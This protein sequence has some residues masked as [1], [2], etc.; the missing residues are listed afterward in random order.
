MQFVLIFLSFFFVISQVHAGNNWPV[1]VKLTSPKLVEVEPGKIVTCNFL[2]YNNQRQEENFT[3]KLKIPPGW[4][5]ILPVES[6]FKLAEKERQARLF[7]FSAPVFCHAGQYRITYVVRSQRD[8]GIADSRTFTVKVLPVSKLEIFIEK[9]PEIVIAG[10]DYQVRL[11][12]INRGNSKTTIKLQMKSSCGYP[13]KLDPSEITLGV[14]ESQ[15]LRIAVKTDR[16]LKKRFRHILKIKAEAE[17]LQNGDAVT[18]GTISVEIIPR[19][20]I[21][22]D[23][24][25]RFPA[26]I[27]LID[28]GKDGK[29]GFQA[30]FAGSGYLSEES[31]RKVSF[32]F[33]AKDVQDKSIY[34][35][36]SVYWFNYY[37]KLLSLHFG[38]R[39]Y[40][41]SPLTGANYGRGAEFNIHPKKFGFGSFYSESRWSEQRERMTG[42]HLKY[43][44]NDM[45]NIKGNFLSKC[46]SGYSDNIYSMQAEIGSTDNIALGLEYGFSGSSR[47]NKLSDKAYRIDLDGTLFKYIDY[48]FEKIYA[49]PKYLGNYN[50]SDHTAGTMAFSIFHRLRGKFF[51]YSHKDNLDLNN[52]IANR[53]RSY[54]AGVSHSF[55]SGTNISLDYKGSHTEDYLLPAEYDYEIKTIILGLGQTFRKLS[56]QSNIE[57]GVFENK[58]SNAQND[59]L[60]KYSLYAYLHPGY[61]QTY[62]FYTI[63]GHSSFTQSPQREKKAGIA[64]NWH[65]MS[66]IHFN[67]NYR[68]DKFDLKSHWKENIYSTFIYTL[69]NNLSLSLRGYWFR[70]KE[71]EEGEFSFSLNYTVPWKIPV[72]RKKSAGII[73]GRVYNAE[74]PGKPPI[75]NVI[76]TANGRTAVT[77]R[78]GG[79]IFLSLMPGTCFLW[80][81]RNSVGL[82]RITSE[83]LPIRLEVKGRETIEIEI[84]VV[85][86]CKVSGRIV[87][88]TFAIDKTFKKERSAAKDTIFLSGLDQNIE[89]SR[90]SKNILKEVTGAGNIRVEITNGKETFR[91]LT[92]KNG[93]FSFEGIRPGKWKLKVYENNLPAYHYFEKKEFQ[94]VL[95]PGNEDEHIIKI[96]PRYRHIQIIEEGEIKIENK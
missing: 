29:K 48:S 5:A 20:T 10:E 32:L 49:G 76:L 35:K 67:L 13:A 79:F 74:K 8:Y 3:E 72:S 1:A 17:N 34:G 36:R 66:N 11:R 39:S 87:V 27:R 4:Q 16:K 64:F 96:L 59:N 22:F 37:D 88:F 70:Y 65:I 85:T 62:T 60:E 63:I 6:H 30:E 82:N 69:P 33:R 47:E 15:G 14:G 83:K 68:K 61:G 90:F 9:K 21:E 52:T 86:S 73:K 41:L 71:R 7:A 50:D 42:T 26:Q 38:D 18:I 55:F 84:G 56:L 91:Q 78:N 58:I 57:K 43:Q 51:Y 24:Y 53:T 44:L 81:E 28:V 92:E 23:P 46:F 80:V 12:L 75:P 94:I 40:S 93:K 77:D 45:L 31:K 95:K 19:V 2:V 25:H 54:Q 89:D